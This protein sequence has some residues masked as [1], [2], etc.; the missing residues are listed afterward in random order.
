M[1]KII[2]ARPRCGEADPATQA[3]ASDARG[4]HAGVSLPLG[5]GLLVYVLGL[6]SP[7]ARLD[8]PDTMLHVVIGRWVLAH[9][10]V[11]H[12]DFLSHTVAGQNWVA[13][14]WLGGIIAA[15]F[16]DWL[17]WHGLVAMASLGL[18]ISIAIF[19][20]AL[21]R[22]FT[23]TQAIVIACA[24]WAVVT[25][26]WLARPHI[27][28]LPFLVLWMALL[29]RARQENRAPPLAAALL[30]IPWVN[31]HGTFLVGI[32]FSGLLTVEA[33]LVTS[34]EAARLKAAKDWTIFTLAAMLASL[35]TPYGIEA[36]LLPLRLLDMKFALS[37]LSEWKSIDFQHLSKLELWLL[38]FLG[39]VL[40]R[41]IRLPPIRVLLVLLLLA[42]GLQH[43]RNGDLIAFMAPLLAAPWAGAQLARAG[44][45]ARRDW[46]ERF[47]R[48]ATARGFALA[49]AIVAAGEAVALAFPLGPV[50]Q[51]APA[52]AVRAI[53]AAGITGPVLNDYNYGDYL[54]FVGI[55]TFVDGRADMFGDPFIKRYYDATHGLSDELPALIAEYK[56]AWTIFPRD[57]Q[58]VAQLDHM[59]GWRRFYADATAV[60]HVRDG[61]DG[62]R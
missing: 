27:I 8:D 30:M 50:E 43:T 13:H 21:L 58:A 54:M 53:A 46:L 12:A 40:G 35:A 1:R 16:Y 42:M 51:Y 17:G 23:P 38:V 45:G 4:R 59:P 55:K 11:P 61:A 5:L 62:A 37:T 20:R 3:A 14:E 18:A 47:A 34:G 32:G 6:A 57:A 26:H 29:V 10:A 24:A 15:L 41:G 9:Q 33:V 52:A 2:A 39:I 48:P 22:Y 7:N 31:I 49:A 60:V 19:A 44:D 28:A 36:Y 56:I 25:P